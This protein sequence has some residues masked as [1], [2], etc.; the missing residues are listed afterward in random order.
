MV[1][2]HTHHPHKSR[3]GCIVIDCKGDDL[4]AA[5]EF[6]AGLTGYTAEIDAKYPAYATLVTP[7]GEPRILLQAVD[8]DS[9][10]HLD[11]ETDDREREAARLE[12]LGARRIAEIKTWI[13]MEAPT[14][15][16]FCLV[17]PQRKDFDT[18]ATP[19]L[20]NSTDDA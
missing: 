4:T 12:A 10:V 14:G 13:V 16:R 5:S 17:G 9:R 3:I 18:N 20:N 6:W 8:H 11:I 2:P 15:H 7:D 19:W 1:E